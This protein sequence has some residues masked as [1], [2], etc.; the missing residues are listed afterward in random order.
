M[1][2]RNPLSEAA[3][4]IAGELDRLHYMATE[5]AD[6]F[7]VKH[8]EVEAADPDN[9]GY[10]GVRV[11]REPDGGITIAWF[12][13]CY[14]KRHQADTANAKKGR[15]FLEHLKKGK[16]V[17]YTRSVFERAR[18]KPWEIDEALEL[19]AHFALIRRQ[20]V[21]LGKL[22]RYVSEYRRGL[23][24]G[25]IPADARDRNDTYRKGAERYEASLA[26]NAASESDTE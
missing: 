1:S 3:D 8:W 6:S 20:V 10:L 9:R 12:R 2:P 18:C 7:W 17:M 16:G 5:L 19:E 15:P 22:R 14:W 21:M 23:I 26:T 24:P 4:S 11:R 13:A 25:E